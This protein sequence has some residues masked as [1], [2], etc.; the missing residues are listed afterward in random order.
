M[1][2]EAKAEYEALE[3]AEKA[4][5]EVMRLRALP[6]AE[7]GPAAGEQVEAGAS[8]FDQKLKAF[9]SGERVIHVPAGAVVNSNYIR[10]RLQ[11]EA[12]AEAKDL[13]RARAASFGC[14]L[15]I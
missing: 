4:E 14:E 10:E 7:E 12:D 2:A 8:S 1:V 5:A 15:N 6:A 13:M 9:W 3:K 11:V